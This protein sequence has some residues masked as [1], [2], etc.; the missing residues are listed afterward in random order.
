MSDNK[1]GVCG[2]SPC[3]SSLSSFAESYPRIQTHNVYRHHF[4]LS[5]NISITQA[6][7]KTSSAVVDAILMRLSLHLNMC[8]SQCNLLTQAWSTYWGK[9][10]RALPKWLMLHHNMDRWAW[11]YSPHGNTVGKRWANESQDLW[12]CHEESLRRYNHSTMCNCETWCQAAVNE[13]VSRLATFI[14]V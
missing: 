2:R 7:E 12:S 5:N 4:H 11:P 6:R 13:F 8:I 1:T 10:N 3:R 9:W 14:S